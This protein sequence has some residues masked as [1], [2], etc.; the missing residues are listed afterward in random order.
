LLIIIIFGQCCDTIQEQYTEN[1]P[2]RGKK[3][4]NT[5]KNS[6]TELR[7]GDPVGKIEARPFLLSNAE[8]FIENL[9]QW[10]WTQFEGRDDQIVNELHE[11]HEM[12]IKNF[13]EF[14]LFYNNEK[15][16]KTVHLL[17]NKL[18]ENKKLLHYCILH[19]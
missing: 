8:G 16:K 5:I 19:E 4:D 3:W 10:C 14:I 6:V 12:N 9:E 11:F 15:N 18:Y 7:C 17:I 13:H 2:T 1:I